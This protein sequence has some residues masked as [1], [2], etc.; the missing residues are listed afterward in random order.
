MAK[1][2]EISW[3]DQMVDEPSSIDCGLIDV[4]RNGVS[5]CLVIDEYGQLGCIDPVSGQWMWHISLYQDGNGTEKGG[6][7]A[8]VQ[9]KAIDLLDFP[10]ILPDLDDDS[11]NDLLLVSSLEQAHHNN[12]LF[13]SGAHGRPL[14]KAYKLLSCE[15]IHK[16]QVEERD[17]NL[18]FNCINN[19]TEQA[20]ALSLYELFKLATGRELP[21]DRLR[22]DRLKEAARIEQ[23]KFYGQR[24]NTQSQ[25]NIY[26]SGGGGAAELI[27]EN[28]GK[29]PFNCTMLMAVS[30]RLNGNTVAIIQ[31]SGMYGMVPAV[32]ERRKDKKEMMYSGFVVKFWEWME[33]DS[34][35]SN[36]RA[37]A[38]DEEDKDLVKRRLK[39]H[40][41]LIMFNATTQKVINTSQ[42][43]I[44]QFCREAPGL[45]SYCQPD[46]NF[47]ENSVTIADLDE[48]DAVDADQELISYYSTF[49]EVVDGKGSGSGSKKWKLVTYVQQFRLEK[50][51]LSL[52]DT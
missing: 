28:S 49:V 2:G 21:S 9:R 15:F 1:D 33:E 37:T 39:E 34:S 43:D 41:V 32:L 4:D 8:K 12:F 51:L 16:L 30:D 29:C 52:N 35:N 48:G 18:V 11:V 23:H 6:S 40:V 46:L 42:S 3:Y 26:P 47:Q 22:G 19:D 38:Q 10:L 14:G 25:R 27:V 36:V 5:D 17:F 45:N 7:G 20:K 44:V 13:V 50:E 24:R 31:G